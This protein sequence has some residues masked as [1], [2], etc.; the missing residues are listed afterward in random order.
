MMMELDTGLCVPESLQTLLIQRRQLV[1]GDR[2]VQMFPIGT[3]ELNVPQGFMRHVNFRGVFHYN[4]DE[5]TPDTIDLASLNGR[6]NEFLLLGPY[7]KN[8]IA[9]R[10]SKGEEVTCVMEITLDGVE[11][12]T[13]AATNRTVKRQ[14]DYFEQ[15][16]EPDSLIL[17]GVYPDRIRSYL[18]KG[19]K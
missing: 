7:S 17:V 4:P 9:K 13:T 6:E 10:V 16:K 3:V 19:K 14:A 18:N 5:I 15:T 1:R 12:R 2:N 11:I 8:D